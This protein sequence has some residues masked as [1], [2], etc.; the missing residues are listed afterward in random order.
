[1][2]WIAS[3]S[4]T[5][6]FKEKPEVIYQNS[7]LLAAF[8]G[9]M[10][11]SGAQ[12]QSTVGELLEKGGKQ[13]TKEDFLKRMPFR[14]KLQWPT[15]QGEEELVLAADGKITGTGYHYSS[16]TDSPVEGTWKLEDDGKICAPKTFTKWGSSSNLCW[17]GFELGEEYFGSQ[18]TDPDSKLMKVGS[19]TKVPG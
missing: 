13:T 12:A 16:R 15:R 4:A 5:T 7:I 19:V 17:Y 3:I 18:K 14:M 2:E 10:A 1:M 11:V 8:V 6:K 9:L